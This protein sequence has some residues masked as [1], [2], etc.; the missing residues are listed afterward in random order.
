MDFRDVYSVTAGGKAVKYI[1][2]QSGRRLWGADK[3]LFLVL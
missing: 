1:L 2:D 3:E